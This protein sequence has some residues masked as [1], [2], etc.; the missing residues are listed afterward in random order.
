MEFPDA[1]AITFVMGGFAREVAPPHEAALQVLDAAAASGMPVDARGWLARGA[2]ASSYPACIA[3]KAAAE[4]GLDGPYLRVLREGLMTGRR[5]L[6]TPDA[7][8]E[9]ARGVAGLDVARFADRR[10]LQRDRRGVRRPTWSA[11]GARWAPTAPC[12]RSRSTA[13]GWAS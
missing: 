12:R 13:R 7:L 3:V 2:A 4:Q 10:A 1:V 11:P 6:D 9:A 5:A 8:I